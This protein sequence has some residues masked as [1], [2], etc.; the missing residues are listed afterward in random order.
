MRQSAQ[1]TKTTRSH[2][3]PGAKVMNRIRVVAVAVL[4][5]FYLSGCESM[6]Q[7]DKGVLG[8]GAI[9]AGTGA[10]VGNALG[11][12]GSGAAIGGVVGAV[13]GGLIGN[14]IEKTEQRNE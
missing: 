10:I 2:R 7:T 12:T 11:H 8:G 4:P 14:S 13:S 1:T 5:L 9:G 6:T 3:Q